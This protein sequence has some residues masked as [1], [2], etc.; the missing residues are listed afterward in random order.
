MSFSGC[1]SAIKA[2]PSSLF[3]N[4]SRHFSAPSGQ[5]TPQSRASTL[6]QTPSMGSSHGSGTSDGKCLCA[7]RKDFMCCSVSLVLFASQSV[8]FSYTSFSCR[9]DMTFAVYWALKNNYLSI[10]SICFSVRLESYLL[11]LHTDV[12][13][14]TFF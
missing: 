8:K 11:T 13:S 5:G 7:C 4:R 10:Y 6:P 3:G 12:I 14:L 9:L 1:L 2:S